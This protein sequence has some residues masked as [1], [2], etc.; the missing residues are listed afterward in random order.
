MVGIYTG[1]IHEEVKWR[2]LF[3]VDESTNIEKQENKSKNLKTK[4]K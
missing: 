2:P 3:I 1:S 4:N